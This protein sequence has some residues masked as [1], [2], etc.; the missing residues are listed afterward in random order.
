MKI[1][2]P[3]I[4]NGKVQL[5]SAKQSA[6][7]AKVANA[8][9]AG[10]AVEVAG[11]GAISLEGL[12][13]TK[14]LAESQARADAKADAALTAQAAAAR[15]QPGLKLGIVIPSLTTPRPAPVAPVNPVPARVSVPLDQSPDI[16]HI[17]M[18]NPNETDPLFKP[19]SLT[20]LAGILE[21]VLPSTL[22][23]D[24]K[25]DDSQELAVSSLVKRRYG[26][27]IGAAGTG[28]TTTVKALVARLLA[29]AEKAGE[30]LT[31]A[32]CAFTGRAVQQI[33]RALPP[34]YQHCCDTMHG[35]L[36]YAPEAEDR[37]DPVT[38][39][40]KT[41]RLFKPR[42]TE[43][44]RTT[45]LVIIVD[46]GG[47]VPPYLWNNL[48]RARAE[49][50]RVYLLGDINQLPPVQGR[51]VLGFAMLAWPTFGLN[52][53]WR[54]NEDDIVSAAW[55]ILQGKLPKASKCFA[56][57]TVSDNSVTAGQHFRAIVQELHK[58]GQFD[59]M[60]DA[61]IVPQNVDGLGQEELNKHFVRYFNQPIRDPAS[62]VIVNPRTVVTGGSNHRM[63]AIG[64]KVMV[65]KNDREQGLT[66]GMLGVI[67]AIN[68]NAAYRGEVVGSQAVEHEMA[69]VEDF[70]LDDMHDFV[71]SHQAKDDEDDGGE[72]QASHVVSI[73]FQ[74]TDEDIPFSTAGAIASLQH[75]YAFTC[76]KAQGGEYRNVVVLTHSANSKMLCREWLY[77]AVTR[78]KEKVVYV[79][80]SRGMQQSLNTQRIVGNTLEEKAKCFIAIQ[81]RNAAEMG[82][83]GDENDKM[84]ILP[85]SEML[86]A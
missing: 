15:A 59:P 83:S 1:N 26:C 67:T 82:D 30:A 18:E 75:A 69:E 61:I 7:A 13:F 47:M 29:Q 46:E 71:N 78:A 32:F 64:D 62:G 84:P 6:A 53:I 55:D 36:E 66:N 73:R 34:E 23:G 74:N 12:G 20:S 33:K 5:A 24:I 48:M 77:T 54:T 21:H 8:T 44:N 81:E 11:I 22:T 38:N 40:W 35:L 60:L 52:R 42:R 16:E 56:R 86:A 37:Y 43:Y 9:A 31:F 2:I 72:R 45:Q 4:P 28:K 68:I 58:R 51:S 3:S 50:A 63:F 25:L 27:I 17:V 57:Q 79:Y 14:K 85:E 41:I 10:K 76:H 65:T 49:G 70:S 80:N 19:Q 39:K